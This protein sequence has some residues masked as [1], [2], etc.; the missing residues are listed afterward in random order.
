MI[1]DYQIICDGGCDFT[2]EQIKK[3]GVH[4][5]PFYISFD[6]K[7]YQ[8]EI[9]EIGI[10]EVYERMVA[11]TRVI[12]KTSLP[13]VQD[14]VDVFLEYAKQGKAIICF[15]MT[16]TLSGSYNAAC[17]A[18]EIV[19]ESYPDAKITVMNSLHCTVTEGMVLRE[20]ARM[21]RAGLP[22]EETVE[23]I[24]KVMDSG[25][26][27]FTVGNTDYLA[28]GGRIGKVAAIAT[29]LLSLRPI[30]VLK[31]GEI[32]ADAV[33]RGRKK[34]IKKVFETTTKFFKENGQNPEDYEFCV[35]FGYDIEEG[36]AFLQEFLEEFKQY[37]IKDN[38]MLA[39][40]GATVAVHTGPY[41]LGVGM[42]KKYGKVDFSP[43]KC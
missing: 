27:F 36:K 26:I 1:M 31:D 39:Q 4:V 29:N 41:A 33:A 35:G 24:K 12:P 19:K 37:S 10:R 16:L 7:N 2:A 25:R 32:T 34:S 3:Y 13:S 42:V 11:D 9:E 30:I 17:N 15:C 38:T 22:Y 18:K 14:Y 23:K 43:L 6:L 8:R 20:A 28:A 5:I 21:C 40:I